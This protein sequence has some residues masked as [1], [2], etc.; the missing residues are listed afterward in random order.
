M[1]DGTTD[2]G[3]E[4]A[5]LRISD[6][7]TNL[8]LRVYDVDDEPVTDVDC[9]KI[10]QS[11]LHVY[12][13]DDAPATDVDAMQAGGDAKARAHLRAELVTTRLANNCKDDEIERLRWSLEQIRQTQRV[14]ATVSKHVEKVHAK[15]KRRDAASTA[16]MRA[17]V[18]AKARSHLLSKPGHYAALTTQFPSMVAHTRPPGHPG[19][20]FAPA[21]QRSLEQT[22]Q[23]HLEAVLAEMRLCGFSAK[24]RK[25]TNNHH[26][27][28][29]TAV[30]HILQSDDK[31]RTFPMMIPRNQVTGRVGP[32]SATSSR[33]NCNKS[34]GGRRA[35]KDAALSEHTAK[36]RYG[37][38]VDDAPVTAEDCETI[39]NLDLYV[40]DV[41]DAPVTE[42]DCETIANLGLYVYDVDDVD[43]APVTEVDSTHV[44]ENG[45]IRRDETPKS[46][47]CRRRAMKRCAKIQPPKNGKDDEV[48]RLRHSREQNRLEQHIATLVEMRH[49]G[50]SS[51][52]R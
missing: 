45:R 50:F 42:V 22:H 43:D 25:T 51:M 19:T 6:I 40:Y 12:D 30:A 41:D 36:C 21:G 49:R 11:D 3:N 16:T 4:N 26:P 33:F 38:D 28:C 20:V 44:A 17:E 29:A 1:S 27:K 18:D 23:Q 39:A 35:I 8:D 46:Q 34:N 9:V 48:E 47:R 31:H 24:L 15:K 5:G 13:G 32:K 52:R 10:V 37:S 7:N 2:V 14:E